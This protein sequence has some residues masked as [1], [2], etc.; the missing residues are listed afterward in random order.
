MEKQ[1]VV[2][3][4]AGPGAGKSY[5]ALFVAGRLKKAGYCTELAEEW[6]KDKVYEKAPYPFTDQIYTFAK[7]RKKIMMRL[8]DKNIQFIVTD[9]PILLSAIYM[10]EPD[11][12]FEKLILRE[13]NKM[14][15]INFFIERSDKRAYEQSGRLHDVLQ[16]RKID[17]AIKDYL[18]NNEVPYLSVL[19][20][21][22][23][24]QVIFNAITR[25]IDLAQ[26]N[27]SR[28]SIA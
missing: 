23:S 20:D 28:R 15:S 19:S 7:Q 4:F 10:K 16:A 14:N 21:E 24:D 1:Y 3:L 9:S 6:I 2:N 13:F 26:N 8:G 12:L 5:N 11:I 18:D 22:N 25:R 27:G 17:A